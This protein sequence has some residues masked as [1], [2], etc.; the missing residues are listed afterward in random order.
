MHNKNT[1]HEVKT[2]RFRFEWAV[3]HF[4]NCEERII[5]INKIRVDNMKWYR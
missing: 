5:Q 2:V 4:I 3:D 1:I